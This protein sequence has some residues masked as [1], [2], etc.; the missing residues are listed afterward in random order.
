MEPA[1]GGVVVLGRAR[2][3]HGERGHGGERPV[4]G[5]VPDDGEPRAAVG[6]VDER[7]AVAAVVRVGELAQA[8]GAGRGVGGDQGPARAGA[9]PLAAMAKDVSPLGVTAVRGDPLD[10]GQRGRVAFQLAQELGDRRRTGLRP[11]RTRR[12]RRCRRTR[13]GRGRWPGCRRTGG[14]R[15]PGRSP[16]PGSRCGPGVTG[17]LPGRRRRA[18]PSR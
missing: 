17:R 16:R 9:G 11:R 15:R 10:A 18:R 2:R 5:H 3:A 14:S 8:V 7:V 12:R 6:A 4:V 13:P 1:V